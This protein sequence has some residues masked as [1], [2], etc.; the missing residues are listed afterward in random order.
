MGEHEINYNYDFKLF[1]TCRM[2]N[3]HLPPELTIKVTLIDFSVTE[4]GLED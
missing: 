4:Q 3:P 1:M 2:A